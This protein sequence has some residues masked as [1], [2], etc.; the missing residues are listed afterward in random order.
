MKAIRGAFAATALLV[1]T[2]GFFS[3]DKVDAP[4]SVVA[5]NIDTALYPPPMYSINP[6]APRKVLIEDYTGH[7]CGNCPDAAV[8]LKNILASNPNVVAVAVHAGS[9]FAPPQPPKYPQDWRTSVGTAFD[10]RF[11]VSAAGQP[12]GLINRRSVNGSPIV[13]HTSWAN[14]VSQF[15]AEDPVA[16]I[17]LAIKTYFDPATRLLVTY[18][19]SGFLQSFSEEVNLGVY[20]VE[21]S[22]TGPQK[23]YNQGLVDDYEPN[24]VHNE[25]L[26]GNISPVWGVSLGSSNPAGAIQRREWLTELPAELHVEHVKVLAFVYKTS[27]NEVIQATELHITE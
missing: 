19:H 13:F 21:D 26:R 16:D 9:T 7:T 22:I 15:L 6:N 4:Y 18:V 10:N 5:S 27:N 17:E 8:V 3:C 12:N 11:G 1:L 2:A 25:M 24:Y 14:L 20:L 23:W